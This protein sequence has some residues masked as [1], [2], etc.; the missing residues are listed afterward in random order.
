MMILKDMDNQ[1]G[2]FAFEFSPVYQSLMKCI[3]LINHF[4]IFCS[5]MVM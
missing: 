3:R 4:V 5:F 1:N 2:E